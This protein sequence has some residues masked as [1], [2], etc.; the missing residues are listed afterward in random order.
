[1]AVKKMYNCS[2]E[3]RKDMEKIISNFYGKTRA[4]VQTRLGPEPTARNIKIPKGTKLE[5]TGPMEVKHVLSV[6][7]DN[8][9]NYMIRCK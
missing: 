6:Q 7:K 4:Q 1:M 2:V 9:K 5:I 3:D 8:G